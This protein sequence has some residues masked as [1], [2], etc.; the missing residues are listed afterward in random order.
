MSMNFSPDPESNHRLRLE[1]LK[2]GLDMDTSH[3][4]SRSPN[5][6]GPGADPVGTGHTNKRVLKH[7]CLAQSL[8]QS[9][10]EHG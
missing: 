4:L 3:T 5:Q 9:K 6:P 10:V 2:L 1:V 7:A 8:A